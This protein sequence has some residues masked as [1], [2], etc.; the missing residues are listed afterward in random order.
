MVLVEV[1]GGTKVQE[2]E[3][4]RE[5]EVSIGDGEFAATANGNQEMGL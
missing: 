4:R 1:E 2:S 3:F 5:W